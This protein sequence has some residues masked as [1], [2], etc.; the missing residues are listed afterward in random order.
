MAGK[1]LDEARTAQHNARGN[2]RNGNSSAQQTSLASTNIATATS[3]PSNSVVTI[4]GQTFILTP[5]APAPAIATSVNT[6]IALS[7]TVF[8]GNLSDYDTDASSASPSVNIALALDRF[9][10]SATTL[11]RLSPHEQSEYKAYVAMTGVSHASVD[12]RSNAV[13]P[14]TLCATVTPIAYTARCAPIT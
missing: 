7:D 5:A 11:V 6:A 9:D 12:W 2:G 4:N 13:V 8:P 1:T 3:A 10:D 14:E